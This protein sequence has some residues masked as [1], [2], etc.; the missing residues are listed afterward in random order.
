MHVNVSLAAWGEMKTL[1]IHFILALSH[2]TEQQIHLL[3]RVDDCSTI[4]I[5]RVQGFGFLQG[6]DWLFELF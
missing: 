5:V 1:L 2:V 6:E 3:K 4:T